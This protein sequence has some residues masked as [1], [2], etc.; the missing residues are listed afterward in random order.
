MI[1]APRLERQT[2]IILLGFDFSSE[3]SKKAFSKELPGIR[4]ASS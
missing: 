1:G 4:V 3:M 2:K